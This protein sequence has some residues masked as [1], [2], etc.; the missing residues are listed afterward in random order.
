MVRADQAEFDVRRGISEIFAKE[1]HPVM[2]LEHIVLTLYVARRAH[3]VLKEG[4]T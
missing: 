4:I 3:L 2:A 1:L